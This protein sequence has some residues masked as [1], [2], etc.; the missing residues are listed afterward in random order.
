[1]NDRETHSE[2][3]ARLSKD[4]PDVTRDKPMKCGRRGWPPGARVLR[5]LRQ[6]A[7]R[8]GK[9]MLARQGMPTESDIKRTLCD[10]SN[11]F[12]LHAAVRRAAQDRP[13]LA[14]LCRYITRPAPAYERVQTDAVGQM[15]PKLKTPWPA[16]LELACSG[17]DHAGSNDR[18]GA[19][20]D[21]RLQHPLCRRQRSRSGQHVVFDHPQQ[22]ARA[23]GLE[24]AFRDVRQHHPRRRSLRRACATDV[25]ALRW[26][27]DARCA[28]G[29][30]DGDGGVPLNPCGWAAGAGTLRNP[31]QPF[32]GVE[33]RPARQRA[34]A[35]GTGRPS[36]DV[37]PRQLSDRTGLKA[38]GHR[39][40]G[41]ELQSRKDR[42]PVSS[43]S[44]GQAI[45]PEATFSVLN[46]APRSC[47]PRKT[48]CE[49]SRDRSTQW[50][51]D[52][53]V[54]SISPSTRVASS[55]GPSADD[56]HGGQAQDH[57]AAV[58]RGVAKACCCR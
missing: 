13:A 5:V 16:P 31:E 40:A 6:P 23:T 54:P 25:A 17:R 21:L 41:P 38:A 35:A 4:L 18:A 29:L 43:R 49:Q 42:V 12:R 52:Q 50:F 24:A 20:A 33:L 51:N 56:H 36:A 53:A 1:M 55:P 15:V 39:R 27:E 57:A 30:H 22:L 11:G 28:C 48:S 3:A 34:S 45:D 47:R 19:E 7:H 58:G 46:R 44:C 26:P 37:R 10:G 32:S 8:A 2:A 9:R 14:H